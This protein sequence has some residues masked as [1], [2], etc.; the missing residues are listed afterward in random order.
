MTRHSWVGLWSIPQLAA[1]TITPP[2][3]D[4]A[5]SEDSS[6]DA[7]AR[8]VWWAR[9]CGMIVLA[10]A[11]LALAGWLSG[12][13]LLAS[14]GDSFIPMAP[15]TALCFTLLAIPL[16]LHR[17]TSYPGPARLI[18]SFMSALVVLA[19]LFLLLQN[20]L[21]LDLERVLV[22]DTQAFGQVVTG[23]MSPLTAV[24]LLFCGVSLCLVIWR[25]HGTYLGH[26]AGGLAMVV[27]IESLI[28]GLGYV[29]ASPLLYGASII[30]MAFTTALCLGVISMG[31]VF[32][33]SAESFPLRLLTGNSIQA[34]LL[35]AFLP[36]T[37][38]VIVVQGF[39]YRLS[40]IENPALQAAILV[41]L[42]SGAMIG[43]VYLISFATAQRLERAIKMRRIAE[44]QMDVQR[45]DLEEKAALLDLAN[46]GIFSRDMAGII[47]YW[48]K[49]AEQLFGYS[50]EEALGR[51]VSELLA[52]QYPEPLD[53]IEARLLIE[54]AWEGEGTFMKNGGQRVSLLSRWALQRDEFGKPKA[55]L[56]VNVDLSALIEAAHNL[57][58][59]LERTQLLNDI[60]RAIAE[61]HDIESILRVVMA[62]LETQL[63]IDFCGVFLVDDKPDALRVAARGPKSRE[64][65]RNLGTEE[66]K[67]FKVTSPL[68]HRVLDGHTVHVGDLSSLDDPLAERYMA[69]GLR[70]A[71][72]IPL[73]VESMVQGVVSTLRVGANA[74][75]EPEIRFLQQVTEQ[76]AVAMQDARQYMAL[77]R[78][79]DE[80]RKTQDAMLQQE[81]LRALGQMAGG[82]THD[83]NNALSPIVGYSD[84][85]LSSEE[86]L[87]TEG[88]MFIETIR[89]AGYD[90]SAIISRLREFY[91]TKEDSQLHAPLDLNGV[92][93]QVIE[94]TSPR[95]KDI[96]QQ[97]HITINI[98]EDFAETPCYAM[99]AESEVREA[100]MNLVNNSLDAIEE[101]GAITLRTRSEE[102]VCVIEVSD[103]GEGMDEETQRRCLEPFFS[104]KGDRGTGLG[105]G[106]VFGVMQ[107]H[108]GSIEI[109]SA[110]GSGTTMRLIFPSIN[111]APASDEIS[112]RPQDLP[113]FSILYIDDEPHLRELV[114]RMLEVDGHTVTT[115]DGGQSG[116]EAFQRA[117]DENCPFD[118]IISDLGM[119]YV[120]GRQV[121]RAVREICPE[122]PF[123]LLTGWGN[124]LNAE[125][126]IPE[127]VSMV[128]SKPPKLEELRNGLRTVWRTR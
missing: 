77:E 65:A 86:N 43:I 20:F 108:Q 34:Q 55:I 16:I 126:D 68:L 121:A 4:T 39:L 52:P 89:M 35:R 57:E 124:R 104:T 14:M 70:S 31:L 23:R 48:N 9:Y 106:M 53:E 56:K 90:I 69:S 32:A 113:S 107:R 38:A 74:F 22:A 117:R 29:Y 19:A 61:R 75:S 49:G 114:K 98:E 92:T 60:A 88:R 95:W 15:S 83:I 112:A 71:V 109:E 25:E 116:I 84:L 42:T 91:R 66:G 58:K 33:A 3:T 46:S 10:V 123:I 45:L 119:P 51:H 5:S 47:Q 21:A 73:M 40:P 1:S 67:V 79:Y 103:T 59:Q 111:Q 110:P 62:Q 72:L 26:I 50:K 101:D 96:S 127:N 30:P 8:I 125:G 80:L 97:K 87:S 99:G 82:I 11:V 2:D 78:A 13:L 102:S 28:V 115:A 81:R 6:L 93:R 27:F 17:E 76:V 64:L 94:L 54:E 37:P 122:T 18:L 63:D 44:S 24:G 118:I 41:L 100:L 12:Q 36:V 128:L 105:L 85:I 120:G 7:P